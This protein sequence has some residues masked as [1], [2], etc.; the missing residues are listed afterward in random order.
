MIGISE[1]MIQLYA[2]INKFADKNVPVMIVGP[3]GSG[4]ELVARALHANSRR[5]GLYSPINCA[6]TVKSLLLSEFF[7]H[8]K[9][10]FTGALTDRKGL[11]EESDQGT[12]FLDE[13]TET[14]QDLQTAL[15]RFS[16][17]GTYK[18]V[19]GNTE[20]TADVRLITA[21]NR[22]PHQAIE[23]GKLREDLYYR[24]ARFRID[25]P[26]LK[27]R[28]DDI[29]LLAIHFAE[30][31][32]INNE[33]LEILEAYSWPG[34]VRQLQSVVQYASLMSPGNIIENQHIHTKI[35]QDN[36]NSCNGQYIPFEQTVTK[37]AEEIMQLLVESM[38]DLSLEEQLHKYKRAWWT[39]KYNKY[40]GDRKALE[41]ELGLHRQTVFKAIRRFK[42]QTP[43]DE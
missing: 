27:Q 1:P 2:Q 8:R 34:N 38:E 36:R 43:E 4:K 39:E 18:R 13:I 20:R 15:L 7:G 11:F 42:L 23:E 35:K 24:L 26:A 6:A 33:G 25:V 29:E 3:T 14:D 9:G 30:G 19:G 12:V 22:E 16:E 21:T 28:V 17:Y 5:P 37:S 10:A 32:A 31:K 40:G 41:E